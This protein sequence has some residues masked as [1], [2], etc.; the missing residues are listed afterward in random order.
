MAISS[1]IPTE[2][3][4]AEDALVGKTILVTGASDGIGRAAALRFAKL[5][6][7]VALLGRDV[8]KL[9]SVYDDI[10]SLQQAQP[11]ALPFDLART[12]EDAYQEL[13]A[14]LDQHFDG[15]DGLLLNASL[16]GDRKPLAQYSWDQWQQLMQVNVGSN[17][18]LIQALLPMLAAPPKASIVLTSS[19]VG[20]RGKAYWGAYAVSKFAVEGLT[21]V[22]AS[23]LE[24][25]SEIRCNAI[26]P[27][28]VNTRMRR[29]AYPAESPDKNPV[30]DDILA[31]YV[32]LM[33]DASANVNGMSIDAQPAS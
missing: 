25:T 5:G 10:E 21:Q 6:A 15:L 31:S 28:A 14:L 23:E 4:P 7:A 3:Q 2:Y 30:P 16:L 8:A 29:A 9:E 27:G 32:Y 17:F 12:D 13:A 33:D 24:N 18:L 22:L 1:V 11:A 19:G 20:R 26:N